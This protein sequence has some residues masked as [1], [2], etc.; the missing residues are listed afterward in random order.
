MKDK[1]EELLGKIP[2]SLTW[3]GILICLISISTIIF[4]V[5]VLFFM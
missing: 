5:N 2:K 3:I 4:A 1:I